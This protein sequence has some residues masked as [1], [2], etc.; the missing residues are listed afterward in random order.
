MASAIKWVKFLENDNPAPYE[1]EVEVYNVPQQGSNGPF[2]TAGFL[3]QH[4]GKVHFYR[5]TGRAGHFESDGIEYT[6]I[7]V[8]KPYVL[9]RLKAKDVDERVIVGRP[10]Q[11][12]DVEDSSC[13]ILIQWGREAKGP[14]D[15]DEISIQVSASS[16]SLHEQAL[17][18][19]E[20][21]VE[22]IIK[23]DYVDS[24]TL[25]IQE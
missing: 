13:S 6:S 23:E 8:A 7:E 19:T 11:E 14:Y 21:I 24:H 22:A 9:I 4:Y 10:T 5:Y 25:T 3:R 17:F 12:N 1:R 15:R 2:V 20:Q 16:P 18:A